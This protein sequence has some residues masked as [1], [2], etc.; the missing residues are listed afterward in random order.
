MDKAFNLSSNYPKG[1]SNTF[2]GY[3]EEYYPD[4]LLSHITSTNGNRMDIIT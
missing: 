2:K 4:T 3:M 1:D